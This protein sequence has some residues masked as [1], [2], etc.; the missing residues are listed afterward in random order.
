MRWQLFEPD[1]DFICSF[2]DDYLLDTMNLDARTLLFS[3][4]LTNAF[5]VVSLF[6]AASDARRTMKSRMVSANGRW[7]YCWKR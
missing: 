7:R 3:L 6:V 5:M 2:K 4:I 1:L